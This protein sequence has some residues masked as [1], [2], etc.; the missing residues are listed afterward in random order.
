MPALVKPFIRPEALRPK[1]AAFKARP[2]AAAG[3]GKLAGWV[4]H[5]ASPKADKL[6]ET[7]LLWDFIRDVFGETPG[8]ARTFRR[9]AAHNP[10]HFPAKRPFS[11]LVDAG[12]TDCRTHRRGT[13]RPS[14]DAASKRRGK[15]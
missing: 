1:L 12:E 8:H 9:Q 15:E 4:K 11:G 5:L 3:R 14:P 2:S 13:H 10:A 6:K 7:E